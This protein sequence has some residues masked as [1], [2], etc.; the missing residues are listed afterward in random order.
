MMSS[1]PVPGLVYAWGAAGH[2]TVGAIADQLLAE[3]HAEQQVRKL[4]HA[5]ETLENVSIWAD[6]AKGYCHAPLS[7]E[8]KTFTKA[9]PHHHEYHYTDIPFQEME[10]KTGGIGSGPNDVVQILR[11]CISVLIGDRTPE[12]NPHHFT[13]RVALL[14]LTHLVGD[15][16]QPLHVGNAYINEE[17]HMIVPRSQTQLDAGQIQSTRGGNHLL[18]TKSQPLHAWWDTAVVE[19]V[20]HRAHATDPRG[21]AT[22]LLET[23]PGDEKDAG[24]VT[25]WP[26][27][28]AHDALQDAKSA[29]ANLQ[30]GPRVAAQDLTT[31]AHHFVWS[32]TLPKTYDT[33]MELIAEQP[34][35]HAGK[36]LALLLRTIWPQ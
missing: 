16:H 25:D 12:R 5:G 19:R 1:A 35:V 27:K 18:M 24:N 14:M 34:L 26:M 4:L 11:Q 29:H 2:Q 13:P 22:S 33:D 10:Y 3:S 28:W 36:R 17:D 32:L 30:L 6:C 20:M 23:Y 8:M 15:V 9:N 31:H 21:L 7:P